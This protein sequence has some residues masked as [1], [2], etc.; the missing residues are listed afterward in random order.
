MKK[1]FLLIPAFIY[2]FASCSSTVFIRPTEIVKLS[3]QKTY[4]ITSDTSLHSATIH[5]KKSVYLEDGRVYELPTKFQFITLFTEWGKRD[6]HYPI[7]ARIKGE[8]L[9]IAGANLSEK[10]VPIKKIKRISITYGSET[11][12][13]KPVGTFNKILGYSIGGFFGILGVLLLVGVAASAAGK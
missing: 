13:S 7:L 11:G 9:S 10:L 1:L 2:I 5:T 6:I 3:G 12:P 4:S 8:D